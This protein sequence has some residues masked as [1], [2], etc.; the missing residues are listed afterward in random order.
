MERKL[1]CRAAPEQTPWREPEEVCASARGCRATTDRDL[2][3]TYTS[4][5]VSPTSV[6]V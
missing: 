5:R 6:N 1:W 2:L 4:A 3:G